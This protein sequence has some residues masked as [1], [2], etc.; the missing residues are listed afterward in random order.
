MIMI[1]TEVEE[2][3]EKSLEEST[4]DPADHTYVPDDTKNS[5][6]SSLDEF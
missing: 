6:S 5:S 1:Q 3:K 4:T 2:K